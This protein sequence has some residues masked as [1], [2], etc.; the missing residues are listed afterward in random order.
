[1]AWKILRN[2]L[3]YISIFTY[4]SWYKVQYSQRTMISKVCL[5]HKAT[6]VRVGIFHQV[7]TKSVLLQWPWAEARLEYFSELML[8]ICGHVETG[9]PVAADLC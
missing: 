9:S 5:F 3:N 4:C 1:M 6:V 2:E 7:I 8:Y